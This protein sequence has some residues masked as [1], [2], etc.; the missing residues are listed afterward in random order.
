MV[1]REE[2]V[3]N[4]L[5]ALLSERPVGFDFL[6]DEGEWERLRDVE[7]SLEFFIPEVLAGVYA[8]WERESLDGFYLTIARKADDLEAEFFGLCILIIDQT[9]TP[10][11]VC[12][13][14]AA[15]ANEVTWLEC[16]L[17]E[18]G[19]HGMVRTPYGPMTAAHR[20]VIALNG[21]ADKID[22]VYKVGFGRRGG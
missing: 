15:N 9:L 16:R 13:E 5:R 2:D 14:I 19:D 7:G 17:G 6:K 12:M 11:H 8:D 22:W 20:R 4:S 3:A 1:S 10:I 21:R 18:L